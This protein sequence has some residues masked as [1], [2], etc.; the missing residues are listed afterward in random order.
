MNKLFVV[1]ALLLCVSSA[2]GQACSMC[3]TLVGAVESWL[4]DNAT[5]TAIIR[6]LDSICRLVPAFDP[7]CE[8]IVAYGVPKFLAWI[9][10]NEDPSTVCKQLGV[11]SAQQMAT[12]VSM[13]KIA[14]APGQGVVCAECQTV[15]GAIEGYLAKNST[16]AYVEQQLDQLCKLI[17]Q[18]SLICQTV[19]AQEI[20]TI[21]NWLNKKYTPLQVCQNF[22]LC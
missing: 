9:K 18:F 17:P 3:K 11:C 13:Y 1:V 7:V 21:I 15:I 19:I 4:A 14:A 22:A 5:D 20:P 10:E 6:N 16:Q 2:S 8:G 12:V